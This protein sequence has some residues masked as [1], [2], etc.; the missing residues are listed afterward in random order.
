MS[1]SYQSLESKVLTQLNAHESTSATSAETIYKKITAKADSE[2]GDEAFFLSRVRD[3]IID[4]EH[5][6]IRMICLTEGHPRRDIF[7]DTASVAHRGLLPSA[8]CYGSFYKATRELEKRTPAEI[9]AILRDS[10]A[11]NGVEVY[12]YATSSN[13]LL[14]TVTPV[15]VEFFDR[16]KPV[17]HPTG[18]AALFDSDTDVMTAPDEFGEAI[19][20]L[21]CGSLALTAGGFQDQSANYFRLA[22][23]I[24]AQEGVK[25]VPHDLNETRN[26]EKR[27][28]Q[29]A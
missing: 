6:V 27:K 14:S 9:E 19:V 28:E 8:F 23:E 22:A 7:R 15:T 2:I 25:A 13:F 18:L 26:A 4:A 1:T 21:A 17:S 10:D 24:M 11:L 20:F 16:D 29:G 12:Y 3:A 5:Q